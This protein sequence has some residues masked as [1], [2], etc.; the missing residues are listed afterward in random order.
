M[1]TYLFDRFLVT[2][3]P[4]ISI[5]GFL[6]KKAPWRIL[7]AYFI[8][9]SLCDMCLLEL[10]CSWVEVLL[11]IPLNNVTKTNVSLVRVDS[12]TT[13]TLQYKK[14]NRV[15]YAIHY[16]ANAIRAKNAAPRAQQSP[17]TKP[18]QLLGIAPRLTNTSFS[19][20]SSIGPIPFG[21]ILI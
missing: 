4:K 20:G 6:L 1:G 2:N 9:N 18:H 17:S 19:F 16:N 21:G 3:V 7:V 14:R 13:S 11:L 5:R 10:F 12:S 15:R 8:Y